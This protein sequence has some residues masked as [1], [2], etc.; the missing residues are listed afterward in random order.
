[1]LIFFC[2][3]LMGC[4]TKPHFC[5]A[6]SL[7]HFFLSVTFSCSH[8]WSL[9]ASE[10][11]NSLLMKLMTSTQIQTQ[12][13]TMMNMKKKKNKTTQKT[14]WRTTQKNKTLSMMKMTKMK[15]KVK[16]K[17]KM[18]QKAMSNSKNVCC[19]FSSLSSSEATK[20][21]CVCGCGDNDGDC[22][23]VA[24]LLTLH[25]LD[26]ALEHNLLLEVAFLFCTC[27]QLKK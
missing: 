9:N 11:N 15:M 14:L 1:M 8:S 16:V 19:A 4:V 26:D 3:C 23:D 18:T 2:I 27:D 5:L 13:G 17:V 20:V 12:K 25:H 24:H 22:D 10:R 6:F 7:P 21:L